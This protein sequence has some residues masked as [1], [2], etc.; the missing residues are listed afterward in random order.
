M[1]T[2]SVR[3]PT[4]DTLDRPTG[5]F[6]SQ[7]AGMDEAR[8]WG[9]SL[10]A[11]MADY[12]SGSLKWEDVDPGCVFYGPPGTG[13]TTIARALAATCRL[14]LLATSYAKW[15]RDTEGN[16]GDILKGMRGDFE[17][18]KR[19]A[20][21]ILFIDEL[22]TLPARGSKSQH[23]DWYTTIVNSLLELLDGSHGR[24]GVVVIGACN[25]VD[26]LDP[27]LV[28]SG[29]LDR[30]IEI[31][32]PPPAALPHI[33]RFHLN[34]DA[35]TV[36]GLDALAL[37]CLGMTGADIERVV[38][39]ARRMARREKRSLGRNDI[40]AAIEGHNGKPS[41]DT[42]ARIAIHEAGHAVAA[43]RLGLS[44]DI[45]LT[46]FARGH[47]RGFAGIKIDDPVVTR[48]YL[49]SVLTMLVAGRAAEEL[50]MGEVSAGAG[51]GADSD[52]GRAT[53]LAFQAL[54]NEGLSRR[55]T[56]AWHG[57]VPQDFRF[58]HQE[59]P[60]REEV[61]AV[62]CEAYERAKTLLGENDE[63]FKALAR[64]LF[65]RRAL[66]HRDILAI[67]NATRPRTLDEEIERLL[68]DEEPMRRV[69]SRWPRVF[70]QRLPSA[71]GEV[72]ARRDGEK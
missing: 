53:M 1:S 69:L 33:L 29:R 26:R 56:L 20:P 32:L 17:I 38:R 27:A 24:P 55:P 4:F 11:D 3:E 16:Q 70:E 39:E 57:I 37:N 14:P 35:G 15:Q 36:R 51:G 6:L 30:T 59:V 64:E 71:R 49:N 60:L 23:D 9:E 19:N 40:A 45:N 22:D 12:I 72:V 63:F 7:L 10:A 58:A 25:D 48:D 43:L 2:R 66:S 68:L 50:H 8:T 31:P 42:L 34:G 13:K 41:P 52:L 47:S 46:T 61:Q 54:G 44:S 5:P 28:R 62:L 67:D 18:A 65:N 21:C